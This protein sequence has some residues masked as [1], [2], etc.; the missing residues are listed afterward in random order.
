MDNKI[1][2]YIKICDLEKIVHEQYLK[3]YPTR[4]YKYVSHVTRHA[5]YI[6]IRIVHYEKILDCF[7][8]NRWRQKNFQESKIFHVQSV[9]C[10]E[11][12]VNY[13]P[14]VLHARQNG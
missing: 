2:I 6:K 14:I 8:C 13:N 9:R 3:I 7:A 11:W 10:T 4:D 12:S 5:E 1:L